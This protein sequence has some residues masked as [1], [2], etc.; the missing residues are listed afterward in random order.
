MSAAALGSNAMAIDDGAEPAVVADGI[1]GP[2]QGKVRGIIQPPP[3]IRAI[4][5]KTARFVAKNGKSFEQRI[6][7]SE[8]GRYTA[9]LITFHISICCFTLFFRFIAMSY[10]SEYLSSPR[11][12]K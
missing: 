2:Q 7:N 5:D 12:S 10:L 6:L 8:E 4:A 3:D 11:P 1:E 9:K